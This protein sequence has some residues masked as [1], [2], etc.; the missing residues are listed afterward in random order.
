MEHPLRSHIE[1]LVSLTDA[2]FEHV[3]SYFSTR[4]FKKHQYL[5]QAGSPVTHD[6]WVVKGLA[7]AYFTDEEGKDHIM[8]FAMEDWWVSDYEAYFNQTR[9]SYHVDCLEPVE[10]LCL[11]LQDRDRL[12]ADLQKMEHFFRKKSNQGYV[13]LQQR[14]L[15]LLSVDAAGR[16]A[17]LVQRYPMLLQ[18]VPKTLIAAYLGVSRETLS[19]LQRED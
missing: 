12:C 2:E 17:Q 3:L 11:S 1:Q 4:R 14:I 10:V 16:Y 8:Q 7:K 5:I 18:R 6:F 13:A 9:A 19:R 15:S